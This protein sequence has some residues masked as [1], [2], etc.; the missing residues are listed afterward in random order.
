[1]ISGRVLVAEEQTYGNRVECFSLRQAPTEQLRCAL[2]HVQTLRST[3]I[4]SATM[5]VVARGEITHKAP[6]IWTF[7]V[8]NLTSIASSNEELEVPTSPRSCRI[9]TQPTDVA[10]GGCS[11]QPLGPLPSKDNW[12][13]GFFS[14][15]FH[16]L[17]NAIRYLLH[18]CWP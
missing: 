6:R 2:C 12:I 5:Q 8:V 16:R 10:V 18:V 4:T 3:T 15:H 7:P 9:R 11:L 17:L 14:L 13:Y 1:M